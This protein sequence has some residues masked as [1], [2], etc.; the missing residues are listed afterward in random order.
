MYQL[1]QLK[2]HVYLQKLSSPRESEVW[3]NARKTFIMCNLRY[4][5]QLHKLFSD[6]WWEG[7]LVN[8]EECKKEA[9]VAYVTTRLRKTF[10]LVHPTN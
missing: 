10:Y 7:S 4:S 1:M 6:K 8:W 5:F 9:G 2:K 3:N